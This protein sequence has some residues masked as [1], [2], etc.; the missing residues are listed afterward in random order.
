MLIM[1][2]CFIV[3][4]SQLFIVYIYILRHYHYMQFFYTNHSCIDFALNKIWFPF[5]YFLYGNIF[6]KCLV[7][8]D[9]L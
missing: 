6:S 3:Y 8:L 5:E 7:T 9:I 4:K 2:C 1:L